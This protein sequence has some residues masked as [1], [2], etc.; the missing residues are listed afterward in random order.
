MVTR[1]VVTPALA[2]SWAL[3]SSSKIV[4]KVELSW[5]AAA[6]S[7]CTATADCTENVATTGGETVGPEEG[8]K[9]VGALVVGTPVV[10]D[11]VGAEVVG[12]VVG[13][14]VVGMLVVGDNVGAK[15]GAGVGL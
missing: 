8:A 2:A 15:L 11:R 13:A 1:S 12:E 4:L 7:A 3:K 9:V 10:G 14:T 5:R 6:I